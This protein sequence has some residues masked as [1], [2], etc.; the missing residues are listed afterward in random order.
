MQSALASRTTK[1]A[2]YCD[3]GRTC[4]RV[5]VRVSEFYARVITVLELTSPPLSL[6]IV[7]ARCLCLCLGLG[8]GLCFFDIVCLVREG[9]EI[10][11]LLVLV[12]LRVVRGGGHC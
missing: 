11:E 4:S 5:R 8:L 12:V 1:L 2:G 9:R 3:F 7:V 6:V 10:I